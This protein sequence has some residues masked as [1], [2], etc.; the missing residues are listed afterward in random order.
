ML[1]SA[2]KLDYEYELKFLCRR[3][4]SLEC[5]ASPFTSTLNRQAMHS[6]SDES[7]L[8]I[9]KAIACRLFWLSMALIF[10]RESG[11]RDTFPST[12][13]FVRLTGIPLVQQPGIK[14]VVC[15]GSCFHLIYQV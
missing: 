1:R 5:R 8:K 9:F 7:Y 15:P 6:I 12:R 14:R 2:L 3:C 4:T 13:L 11:P 10:F